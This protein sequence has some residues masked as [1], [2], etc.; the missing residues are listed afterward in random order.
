MKSNSAI[1]VGAGLAGLTAGYCLRKAGWQVSVVDTASYVGGRVATVRRQG[2]TLDSGATQLSSGY[3]EYLVLCDDLG[4]GPQVVASSSHVGVIRRG[5]IHL[6]DARHMASAPFTRL[7]SLRGKWRLLRTVRDFLAL[8]P[9]VNPLDVSANYAVDVESTA[10]YAIRRIDQEVYEALMDPLVRAYVM[11]RGSNVSVLE[12]FSTL[13]ILSGQTMLSMNEGNDRLPL[14]LAARLD[15]R[16]RCSAVGI[17]VSEGTVRVDVRSDSTGQE[18]LHADGCILATR[19][20]EAIA[21]Y[22]PAREIAGRLGEIARYNRG[23]VV[24][25][26]YSHRPSCPAVGLLLGAAEHDE[27]GLIWLEHNKN[28]DRAPL[29]HALFTVYFDEAVADRCYSRPDDDLLATSAAYIE[30]LF[31]KLKGH[32][33]FSNVTRWPLGILNPSPGIY[34][35]VHAM[36]LRLN[37]HDP[38]QL[39]GDY[40][41]CVGQNSAV[42]YG[43]AAAERLLAQARPV[44][45]TTAAA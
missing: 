2:Y 17:S 43:K 5:Q 37:P 7:L 28:S 34:R 27:I 20:P 26:G 41:T 8:R 9:A 12:W 21:L 19:L 38:V 42:H 18:S 15:V 33:D 40:F 1:V 30:R 16:L 23:L 3:G 31:P 22:P 45:T 32:R 6:I 4:L 36:K 11:N 35:E 25:I 44:R 39:A 24:H 14:A 29:G 13:K 10:A